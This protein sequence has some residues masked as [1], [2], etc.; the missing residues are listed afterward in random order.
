MAKHWTSRLYGQKHAIR[1]NNREESD[2]GQGLACRTYPGCGATFSLARVIFSNLGCKVTAVNAQPDGF[3]PARS[4][5]PTAQSL[6]PLARIVKQLGADVG[7]AY[8]GDG[9]RMASSTAGGILR[10][11]TESWL[12]MRP[13]RLRKRAVESQLLTLKRRCVLKKWLKQRVEKSSEQ[14]TIKAIKEA[15]LRPGKDVVIVSV[16]AIG[17][18]FKA[19]IAGE[20]NCSVECSPS[21]R[22]AAHEGNQRLHV[23]KSASGAHRHLGGGLPCGGCAQGNCPPAVIRSQTRRER[24]LVFFPSPG[25][26]GLTHAAGRGGVI[27]W[28]KS[29]QKNRSVQRRRFS[30]S[31]IRSEHVTYFLR[32]P[33]EKT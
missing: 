30:Q 15:G 4:S 5:E 25:A 7:V 27:P 33:G 11:L 32:T 31:A 14:R 3:F 24:V 22:P 23:G 18:A 20:L 8:D 19:M 6:N 17:D 13:T 29:A 2:V 12:H 10:I 28:M 1:G 21:A 9:D 26:A 16:D